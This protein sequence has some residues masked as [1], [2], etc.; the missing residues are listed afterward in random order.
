MAGWDY[1]LRRSQPLLPREQLALLR[2]GQPD[3]G[4][5]CTMLRGV[6]PVPSDTVN[7]YKTLVQ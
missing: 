4:N 2:F 1:G 5:V 6:D 7:P 3:V